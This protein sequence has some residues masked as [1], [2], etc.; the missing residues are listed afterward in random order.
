[1]VVARGPRKSMERS[2]DSVEVG[3]PGTLQ[4]LECKTVVWPEKDP[5][6][7]VGVGLQSEATPR[8]ALFLLLRV[9]HLVGPRVQP[10]SRA[11]D[12]VPEE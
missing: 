1:M 6:C 9:S 2:E 10:C 3:V 12:N 5:G 7:G 4:A 8:K 11:Q